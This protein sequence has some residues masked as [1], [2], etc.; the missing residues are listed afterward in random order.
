MHCRPRDGLLYIYFSAIDALSL[1]FKACV[2]LDA[3]RG[4]LEDEKTAVVADMKAKGAII[5]D[6]AIVL[7]MVPLFWSNKKVDNCGRFDGCT[8][9]RGLDLR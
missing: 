6:S 7:D 1:G 5:T 3:T 2:N 8:N 9:K 4:I